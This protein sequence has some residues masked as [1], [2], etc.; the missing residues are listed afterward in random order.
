MAFDAIPGRVFKAKVS[1]VIDA[2]ATGQLQATGSLQDMGTDLPGG[3]A[4]ALIDIEAARLRK[5]RCTRLTP[6][7]LPLFARF[8]FVCGAG[9]ISYSWRATAEGAPKSSPGRQSL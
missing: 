3:R 8:Y 5:S 2:I 1:H 6:T 4:V 7:I 9:R